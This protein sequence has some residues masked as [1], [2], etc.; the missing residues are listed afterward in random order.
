MR[1]LNTQKLT[2]TYHP[3][4]CLHV[5][6]EVKVIVFIPPNFLFAYFSATFIPYNST[7][8]QT[9]EKRPVVSVNLQRGGWLIRR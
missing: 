6:P 3:F 5:A 2:V 1:F 7:F 4:R 8:N 9:A